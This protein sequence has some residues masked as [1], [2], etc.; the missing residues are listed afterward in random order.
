ML[1]V[2]IFIFVSSPT[3][4]HNCCNSNNEKEILQALSDDQILIENRIPYLCDHFTPYYLVLNVDSL[5]LLCSGSCTRVADYTRC[6]IT[7]HGFPGPK[8]KESC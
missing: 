1:P 6:Q 3:V 5:A 2:D 4:P 7:S 8:F